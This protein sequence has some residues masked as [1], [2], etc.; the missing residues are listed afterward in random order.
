MVSLFLLIISI[1]LW[2]MMCL[3]IHQMTK[4][5]VVNHVLLLK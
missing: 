5:D 2:Y 3:I 1:V 4:N